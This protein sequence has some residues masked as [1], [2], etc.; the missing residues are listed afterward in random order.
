MRRFIRHAAIMAAVAATPFSLLACNPTAPVATPPTAPVGPG[1]TPISLT[2]VGGIQVNTT[3]AEQVR[4]MQ[5]A[6]KTAGLTL[7]GGGYR[8]GAQQIILRR[9]HCGTSDYAIYQMP[10]S[11]CVPPTARPGSSLHESG[12]AI[13]FD[14]SSTH[15]TAVYTWLAANASRFGFYNLPSEPWHWSTNGH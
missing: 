1:A 6:A 10:S 4:A 3:I 13:D 5:A 15:A 12:L 8:S 9:E 14:R 11:Q 2:M 7:T